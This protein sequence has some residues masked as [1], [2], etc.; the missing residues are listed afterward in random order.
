MG[1]VLGD[2]FP[3]CKIDGGL[4]R[5][6]SD[7]KSI[8]RRL[9]PSQSQRRRT[10]GL[11]V[12]VIAGRGGYQ[13][14]VLA[15][16]ADAAREQDVNLLCFVGGVLRDLQALKVRENM[17][18]GLANTNTV[19]GL[20]ICGSAIAHYVPLEEFVSFCDRYRSLPI[21]TIG[22]TLQGI[23][24]V[25]VD[26]KKSM[27][28]AVVHL[29]EVHKR[30][31]I[32]FICGPDGSL[33]A[34][35][36]YEGYEDALK[37]HGLPVDLSLVAPGDFLFASGAQA[38]HLLITKRN[39]RPDAIV[40]ANDNM[41]FG[42][43]E[44]LQ[45][46][47][48]HVPDEIALIGYDDVE[49][50]SA[51]MPPL[52]TVHQPMSTL[53]KRAVEILLDVIEK[54]AVSDRVTLPTDL[55]KRQSCGCAEPRV[56]QASARIVVRRGR[57]IEEVFTAERERILIET[58]RAMGLPPT[59]A[60]EKKIQLLLDTLFG[61]PGGELS[62]AFLSTLDG[63][64]HQ[65]VDEGDNVAAWQ[66][67]ISV[68]RRETLTCLH[69]S[70]DLERVE[71]I[72]QQARVTVAE[73]TQWGLARERLQ[74]EQQAA[75]L[76]EV[77]EKLLTTVDVPG[78]IDVLAQELP[79]L[80]IPSCSISLYEPSARDMSSKQGKPPE[81]S[82][83]VLRYEDKEGRPRY[84]NSGQVFQTSQLIPGGMAGCNKRCSAVIEPL[85]SRE[86]QL[87]FALFEMGP[88]EGAV[89]EALRGQI[90]SALEGALLVQEVQ[91]GK[92]YLQ[93]LFR[94]SSDIISLQ[95]PQAVLQDVVQ[96]IREAMGVCGADIVLIDKQGWFR[97]LVIGGQI[98]SATTDTLVSYKS[99]SIEVMKKSEPLFI[100]DMR[101]Q[102]QRATR[103][104][105]QGNIG[106]AACF[107][108]CLMGREPIGV[109]WIYYS[110]S[111]LFAEAEKNALRLYINQAAIAY[112][113]AMHMSALEHLRLA[114]E[115]LAGVAEIQE[116]LQQIVKS[117]REVLQAD[118]V[119]IW[120]YDP[121][122]QAF[123]PT[124]F[125]T[126]G[127]EPGQIENYREDKPQPGGTTEHVLEH[128]YL[129]V[130]NVDDPQYSYLQPAHGLRGKSVQ[131]RFKVSHYELMATRLV[132]SM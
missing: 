131:K 20:I 83:L 32:A 106:A 119:I 42:A 43:L 69:S 113:N 50:A 64:L 129:V 17:I 70:Q 68:L 39:V 6:K 52:T 65:A 27:Q 111:H 115:R 3:P 21:V 22:E 62:D 26:N 46:L 19:D 54:R 4:H 101:D 71:D 116:V 5:L 87:G 73:M 28:D 11:F 130:A 108:F 125:V 124:G 67:A 30:H 96:K 110:E 112:D 34:E 8:L 2:K 56:D 102:I 51:V 60:L 89:Y 23:A 59:A 14:A 100:E 81:L 82:K 35:K 90:S 44:A 99:I 76:R 91:K 66:G 128:E 38:V 122:F 80:K 13:P 74:A 114:T 48:I 118:S 55:V 7:Q 41:A 77:S 36:R 47:G 92:D 37:E 95:E 94:A 24:D 103:R 109:I 15:G 132:S 93:S 58:V 127:I 40:A 84:K 88:R 9:G 104:V 97:R 31:R 79:R 12:D 105:A 10:I 57:T 49:E 126:D 107:P 120:L 33:E 85:C 53:G 78:L 25:S 18:Y 1:R 86:E 16:V 72:W 121:I 117:A 45:E 98:D 61:K 63:I 29:I 123:L 75:A